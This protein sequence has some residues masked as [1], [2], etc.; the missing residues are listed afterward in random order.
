MLPPQFHNLKKDR[1]LV[2]KWYIMDTKTDVNN[3]YKWRNKFHFYVVVAINCV[4]QRESELFEYM[5]LLIIV[6]THQEHHIFIF[7]KNVCWHI[8]RLNVCHV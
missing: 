3:L 5:R 7:P 2:T 4:I 1:K 6:E 8:G